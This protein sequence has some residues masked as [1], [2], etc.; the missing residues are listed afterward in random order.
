[1]LKRLFYPCK[2]IRKQSFFPVTNAAQIPL[3]FINDPVPITFSNPIAK[4]HVKNRL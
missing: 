1:M 4:T 2:K 3:Y